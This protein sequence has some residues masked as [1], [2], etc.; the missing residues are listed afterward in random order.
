MCGGLWE[1][2]PEPQQCL[3]LLVA[4]RSEPSRATQGPGLGGTWSGMQLE[5]W[6]HLR[7]DGW[8][9]GSSPEP[10]LSLGWGVALPSSLYIGPCTGRPRT[11]PTRLVREGTSP[12]PDT[13][14]IGPRG[15]SS[16]PAS[17]GLC[18]SV[19]RDR[20]DRGS[21]ERLSKGTA[22]PRTL[23]LMCKLRQST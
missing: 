14:G 3:G 12:G 17:R 22:S 9:G 5:G 21:N 18:I 19:A 23:C 2:Q 16:F 11:G 4:L 15:S 7:E 20:S 8:V 6:T 13:T 1:G 10:H